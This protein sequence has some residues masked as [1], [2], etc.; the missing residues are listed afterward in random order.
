ME[1]L[2]EDLPSV[3]NSVEPL[4]EDLQSVKNSVEPLKEDLQSVKNSVE[5]GFVRSDIVIQRRIPDKF[6]HGE[7]IRASRVGTDPDLTAFLRT[8]VIYPKGRRDMAAIHHAS[9]SASRAFWQSCVKYGF[10][11][12]QPCIHE[13]RV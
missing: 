12:C 10:E 9:R 7:S 3:K 5:R 6:V 13:Y 4:K 11:Q 8:H 1:P 2:K